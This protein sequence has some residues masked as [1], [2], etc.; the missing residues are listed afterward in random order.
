MLCFLWY[1]MSTTDVDRA[2]IDPI[3]ILVDRGHLNQESLSRTRRLSA[4]TGETISFALTRL[5]LVTEGQMADAFC[6]ALN[7]PRI[8]AVSLPSDKL[9]YEGLSPTFLRHTRALPF[10]KN[11]GGELALAMA[12]PLDDATA[13]AVALFVGLPVHRYVALPTDID[14]AL[15]RLFS[16][17]A[18]DIAG[19]IDA[20]LGEDLAGPGL[21]TSDLDR[22][23]EA[24]SDAP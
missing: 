6:K 17:D 3:S 4:E 5:G 7:L 9:P 22:L 16:N 21:A 19:E 1:A 23:R 10:T 2:L 14:A 24:A 13:E 18:T 8:D 11:D 20:S 12:N 15:D